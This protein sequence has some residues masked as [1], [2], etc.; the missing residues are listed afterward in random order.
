MLELDFDE[1]DYVSSFDLVENSSNWIKCLKLIQMDKINKIDTTYKHFVFR[2]YDIVF[3]IIG[4]DFNFT[5][6]FILPYDPVPTLKVVFK[7]PVCA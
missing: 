2:T 3:E 1:Y 7:L 6:S 5:I 4:K